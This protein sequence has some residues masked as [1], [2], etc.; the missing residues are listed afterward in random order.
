MANNNNNI[1]SNTSSNKEASG[2]RQDPSS[3]QQQQDPRDASPPLSMSRTTW[4]F[5]PLPV[6]LGGIVGV[7]VG[8]GGYN[9]YD[10][11]NSNNDDD[12]DENVVDPNFIISILDKV[13]SIVNE[14]EDEDDDNV[15][16]TMRTRMLQ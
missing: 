15:M 4:R 8:V 11:T 12:D 14:D 16:M 2:D 1:N 13:I 9:Y 10:G 5:P 3:W 7:D 6:P